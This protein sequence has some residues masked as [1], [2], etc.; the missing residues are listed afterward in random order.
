MKVPTSIRH[1]YDDQ[2]DVNERLRAKVDQLIRGMCLSSWHYVSRI[3]D[4]LSFALKLETGRVKRPRALEDFFG[5]TIV[6]PNAAE[7]AEAENLIKA[8][9]SVKERRPPDS[10]KTHKKPHEFP[11]DDLRL[12]ATLQTTAALPASD[13]DSILFEVQI[14]TFLQHAWSVATHD[15]I[16]KNDD[17]NWSKERIAYQIKAMLEHAEISIQ[18][19]ERLATTDALLKEDAD[20][21][22]IR[23]GIALLKTQWPASELPKDVRRLAQN[24]TS[25][26]Q[27]LKLEIA[28]LEQILVAEKAARSGSHPSNL[29]PYSTVLQYL[30]LAEKDKMVDLLTRERGKTKVIIPRELELP[31]DIDPARLVNA[32]FI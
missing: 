16:Y 8:N 28:R 12:Y 15:L 13:I 10:S 19:A 4:E 30:F 9:F 22:Q 17:P 26:L 1:L 3:K 23:M 29:S 11:F 20:T 7:I 24:I 21:A 27:N 2:R 5:C 18:E 31:Q 6:V 14:K 25:L 32:M